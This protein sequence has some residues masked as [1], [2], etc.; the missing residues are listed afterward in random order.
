MKNTKFL[1][2]IILLIFFSCKTNQH[3]QDFVSLEKFNYEYK[4]ELIYKCIHTN[5]NEILKNEIELENKTKPFFSPPP[6]FY[7]KQFSR[8]QDSIIKSH[9]ITDRVLFDCFNSFDDDSI[10]K[11]IRQN[12]KEPILLTPVEG[13]DE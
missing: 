5:A 9:K 1:C 7:I 13:N 8:Q 2:P 4:K 10:D 12:H 3:I 11:L 6:P